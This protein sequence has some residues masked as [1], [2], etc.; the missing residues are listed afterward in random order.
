LSQI[1]RDFS[2][3]EPA[4]WIEPSNPAAAGSIASRAV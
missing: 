1:T 2:L 3:S 4:I